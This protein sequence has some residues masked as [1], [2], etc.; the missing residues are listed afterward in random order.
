VPADR[1]EDGEVVVEA[2]DLEVLGAVVADHEIAGGDPGEALGQ[3]RVRVGAGPVAELRDAGAELARLGDRQE[4]V[5]RQRGLEA[6]D[7]LPAGG[8]QVR[9]GGGLLGGQ[10]SVE[11]PGAAR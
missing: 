6:L 8:E 5:G 2:D 11:V 7:V 9:P 1:V 10:A 3:G 4:L